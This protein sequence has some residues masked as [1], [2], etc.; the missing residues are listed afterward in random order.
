MW[1]TLKLAHVQD[2]KKELEGTSKYLLD[3]KHEK[4]R[5]NTVSIQHAPWFRWTLS[6]S[7]TNDVR[8]I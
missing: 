3:P 8:S 2:W 5:T 4:H 7:S 1:D 6:I